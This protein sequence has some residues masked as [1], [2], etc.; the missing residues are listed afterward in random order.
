MRALAALRADAR[1]PIEEYAERCARL[2]EAARPKE[3]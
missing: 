2:L 3:D 1:E